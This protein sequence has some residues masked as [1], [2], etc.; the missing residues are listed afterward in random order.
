ML[1]QNSKLLDEL[2]C[3]IIYNRIAAQRMVLQMLRN[4]RPHPLLH[5]KH[6]A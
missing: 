2:T 4:Y 5:L 3:I 6:A 1:E